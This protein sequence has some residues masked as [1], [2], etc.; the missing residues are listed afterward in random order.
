VQS[1]GVTIIA[2]RDLFPWNRGRDVSVRRSEET[3]PVL[4]LHR[5]M[6]RLFD[7]VFRGFDLAPFGADRFSDRVMGW[8]NIEVS[9]TDKEVQVTAE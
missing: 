8:P 7:D 2:I 3:N 9:E 5:E 1:T 6:N 4:T